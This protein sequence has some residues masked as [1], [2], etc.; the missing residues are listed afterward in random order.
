MR[1]MGQAQRQAVGVVVDFTEFASAFILGL[2]VVEAGGQAQHCA[3]AQFMV[4]AEVVLVPEV[5]D[6]GG[7]QAG[8]QAAQWLI[9]EA[10]HADA[11][12]F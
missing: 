2:V 11:I 8:F 7:V 12:G 1:L 4:G 6:L 10:D 3:V 9:V 5:F